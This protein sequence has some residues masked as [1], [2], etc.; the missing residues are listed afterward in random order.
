MIKIIEKKWQWQCGSVAVAL[1][2]RFTADFSESSLF[3][4]SILHF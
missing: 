1:Y 4:A 3:R 2:P